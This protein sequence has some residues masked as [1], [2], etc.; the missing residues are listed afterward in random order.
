MEEKKKNVL[1][2]PTKEK[3]LLCK[4]QSAGSSD[5]EAILSDLDSQ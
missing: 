4:S 1:N 2:I 5:S 3:K